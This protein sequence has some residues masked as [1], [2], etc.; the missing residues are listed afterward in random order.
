MKP[1]LVV[2][3]AGMGS[4]YGGLKQMDRFGPAGETLLDYSI[5]DARRA[6]FEKVVFVS[7]RDIV[8]EFRNIV[9]RK[10]QKSLKIDFALQ[11]LD[12]VPPHFKVPPE[13]IKPW[14]TAHAV[15][16]TRDYLHEPFAVINAD[17]FYGF[18]SYQSLYRHLSGDKNRDG[19]VIGYRGERTLSDHG[20][21]SRAILEIDS[22][23]YLKKI[24]ESTINK[25]TDGLLCKNEQ[26]EKIIKDQ[27][28]VSMN[29]MGFPVEIFEHLESYFHK[30]LAESVSEIKSESYLPMFVNEMINKDLV[31]MR[32]YPT[33][34]QWFGVTYREDKPEVE[35]KIN[36]LVEAGE[37]P[38]KLW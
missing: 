36:K 17:D 18:K 26:G 8:D 4:R 30:F 5:Y 35:Q 6:G 3:A 1:A 13:R 16:V 10:Y 29:Q 21:V 22:A 20:T 19:C 15:L 2:L 37:Y 27:V 25:T 7:R 12:M 31:R 23:G 11:E 24:A 28:Y 38:E 34:A 32:V 9:T 33:D 14:G